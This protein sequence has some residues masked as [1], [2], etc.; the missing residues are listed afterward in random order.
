MGFIPKKNIK[1]NKIKFLPLEKDVTRR[2]RL[3]LYLEQQLV[4]CADEDSAY[5]SKQMLRIGSC[6]IFA[7]KICKQVPD[8]MA[9]ELFF[10]LSALSRN[11]F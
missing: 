7:N 3:A 6:V 4:G 10:V 2:C 1:K 9:Q 8:S 11:I 5:L